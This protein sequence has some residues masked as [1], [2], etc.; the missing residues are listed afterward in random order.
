[1]SRSN[2]IRDL[3]DAGKPTPGTRTLIC[4]PNQV[5][6]LGHAGTFDDVEFWR[7][8]LAVHAA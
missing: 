4:R 8:I 3:L 5:E 2:R 7:R 6:A 1:M